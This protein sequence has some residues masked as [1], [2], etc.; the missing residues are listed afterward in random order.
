MGDSGSSVD[1]VA[2]EQP[3]EDMMTGANNLLV[4]LG[5]R[6]AGVAIRKVVIGC[7]RRAKLDDR[8]LM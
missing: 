4:A 3:Y 8:Q 2:L 6:S 7:A 5:F 1:Y